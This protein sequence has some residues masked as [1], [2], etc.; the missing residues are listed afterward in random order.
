MLTPFTLTQPHQVVQTIAS[1]ASAS[2]ERCWHYLVHHSP[3]FSIA[4]ST[5][6]LPDLA[7]ARSISPVIKPWL[8]YRAPI[9]TR[10][11]TDLV[12]RFGTSGLRLQIQSLVS[13][14][15]LAIPTSNKRGVKPT[16][17]SLVLR[18][19]NAQHQSKDLSY[20]SSPRV[21]RTS[22]WFGMAMQK[23]PPT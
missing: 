21:Q 8:C 2:S 4:K 11:A 9:S 12:Q 13:S 15:L 20:V 22:H 6:A 18:C 5:T 17:G 16:T 1:K 7:K 19:K 3:P 10:C 23:A 14:S